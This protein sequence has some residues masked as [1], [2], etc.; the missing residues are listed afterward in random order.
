MAEQKKITSELE[1][2]IQSLAGDIY[3]QIEDKVSAFV[4]DFAKESVMDDDAIE[5]HPHFQQLLK[6]VQIQEEE[7]SKTINRITEE[8]SKDIEVLQKK[9]EELT[10]D[11]SSRDQTI[12][13]TTELNDA[14]LTDTEKVLKE[15]LAEISSIS[16]Q[17]KTL[18]ATEKSQSE[19]L[20]SNKTNLSQLSDALEQKQQSYSSLE[21]NDKAK[22]A[23]LE[24]QNQQISEL[25][26]QLDTASAELELMKANQAKELAEASK[27]ITTE[28]HQATESS[29]QA[30]LLSDQL[31]QAI[32]NLQVSEK[33][34]LSNKQELQSLQDK[35]QESLA[36]L[37]KFDQEKT[38][39]IA[40]QELQ[41][42]QIESSKV[43]NQKL[44]SD[45]EALAKQHKALEDKNANLE[46]VIEE[47]DQKAKMQNDNV[48]NK[49][50][51]LNELTLQI[52]QLQ[53]K[54]EHSTTEV[55]N[56]TTENKNLA[57]SLDKSIKEQHENSVAHDL[58]MKKEQQTYKEEKDNLTQ[59]LVT[60]TE[61]QTASENNYQAQLGENEQHQKQINTLT[62][63]AKA[64]QNEVSNLKGKVEI[65]DKQ[66]LDDKNSIHQ[67]KDQMSEIQTHWQKTT[68]EL[69]QKHDVLDDSLSKANTDNMQYQQEISALNG[70]VSSAKESV[71]SS[72]QRFESGREKQ[73]NEY[74]KARETIKYLRDENLE[75]SSKLEQ[76][77]AE[78]E[79]KV[80]EYRLRFEYAQKQLTNK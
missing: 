3:I 52:E 28:K 55:S 39:A 2:Q 30:S 49:Q 27:K 45:I 50:N 23:T 19:E 68:E 56:L 11:I 4:A 72:Q 13:N 61:K 53:Q 17:L 65:G 18:T 21:K 73:E 42:K 15:K 79:D 46:R 47:G 69:Q 40:Y 38:E 57:A 20:D 62:I 60:E 58:V 44:Q 10:S 74:N 36:K 34:E 29:N 9:V 12:K 37:A 66:I 75:L 1:E 41:V 32:E 35:Q 31:Q 51:E 64:Y 5:K 63:A 76:E 67:L 8:T 6:K 22:S 25:K 48:S 7:Q 24:I 71:L 54:N 77:V 43:T 16:T 78:L 80:R 26:L 70:K 33:N 14:K 59:K